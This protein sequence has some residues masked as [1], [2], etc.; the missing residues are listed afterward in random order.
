M[1]LGC[2]HKG[3]YA[4][5]RVSTLLTVL[6]FGL[7]AFTLSQRAKPVLADSTPAILRTRGLEIVDSTGKLRA[8]I[9]VIPEGPARRADGSLSEQSGKVYP[10]AVV[11]RLIRPDGRPSVKISTTQQGSGV[12]LS[13]GIDPTYMI[14]SANDGDTS[15]TL[16]NKDGKRHVV[17]PDPVAIGI[18]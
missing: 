5:Q 13:G 6:N 10:E 1:A 8:S 3:G 11:L 4:M 14:L 16:I 15:L 12:A 17:G 2:A 9:S 18:K 7:L